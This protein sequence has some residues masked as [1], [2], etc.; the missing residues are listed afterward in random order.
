VSALPNLEELWLQSNRLHDLRAVAHQLRALPKLRRLVLHPNVCCGGGGG[1]GEGEGEGDAA[2]CRMYL[3]SELRG[4]EVLD[5]PLENGEREAADAYLATEAGQEA[6]AATLER[7]TTSRRGG[8]R[9]AGAD[10]VGA[11]RRRG[12]GG[13][14]GGRLGEA[15][16]A[17]EEEDEEE[18]QQQ[19]RRLARGMWGRTDSRPS[20]RRQQKKQ[21]S[22]MEGGGR[23]GQRRVDRRPDHPPAKSPGA[24]R[25]EVLPVSPPVSDAVSEV[26]EPPDPILAN[27][28]RL[29]AGV[30]GGVAPAAAEVP[31]S[32]CPQQEEAD[33]VLANARRLLAGLA[34]TPAA[35]APQLASPLKQRRVR[36]PPASSRADEWGADGALSNLRAALAKLTSE[37]N[38]ILGG[39]GSGG[40]LSSELESRYQSSRKPRLD[41]G[42]GGRGRGRSGRG[43]AGPGAGNGNDRRGSAAATVASRPKR[44]SAPTG[45]GSTAET[46][47]GDDLDGSGADGRPSTGG[48][49]ALPALPPLLPTIGG[50][51]H[52][53]LRY[54]RCQAPEAL[55]CAPGS[56]T[57]RD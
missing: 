42:R 40:G 36:P 12:D 39:G 21:R 51:A 6:L 24:R 4:L 18:E 38:T 17:T 56:H 41:T 7:A 8:G 55:S 47:R 44:H 32:S 2:L 31:V 14:S 53:V 9:T 20:R 22:R 23:E 52:F 35:P 1:G 50:A 11:G 26:L 33:P 49:S 45:G 34:A 46:A 16:A 57:L 15:A 19:P 30:G 29:L 25:E 27:A 5:T 3:L 10:G 54:S 48:E 43:R 37:P 28:R 13:A